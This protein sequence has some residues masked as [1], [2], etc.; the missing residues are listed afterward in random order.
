MASKDAEMKELSG[1][2]RFKMTKVLANTLQ[3]RIYLAQDKAEKD[4]W[5]VVKETWKELVKQGKSRDGHK[6]PENFEREKSIQLYLSNLSDQNEGYVRCIES[7][8]DE[9]CYYL[10]MEY[11]GAGELFDF[12]RD[13]HT[14]GE[15]SKIV[16]NAAKQEQKCETTPNEWSLCVQSMFRQMVDTVSWMHLHGVSHLDL[17]LENTMLASV[18]DKH[19]ANIKI[20]DFGVAKFFKADQKFNEKVG[21]VGYM[22]PEVY[23]KKEY[24]PEK[25]DIWC[26]GVMLFMML[27]GAPPYEFASPTNPAFRFIIAGRLR[28]VLTHWRR[29]PLVSADALNVME[30]IF[31]PENERITMEELRQHKYVNLPSLVDD[32]ELQTPAISLDTK[33]EEMRSHTTRS[34]NTDRATI[35][36]AKTLTID[37]GLIPVVK[38]QKAKEMSQLVQSTVGAENMRTLVKTIEQSIEETT[39]HFQQ[40]AATS[41]ENPKAEGV[42]DEESKHDNQC[43]DE[44]KKLLRVVT[45]ALESIT[46]T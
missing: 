29:L 19:Q 7:W 23:A 26:L 36:N 35:G 42:T 15:Q 37:S 16:K 5:T 4:R 43:L 34:K 8:E 31:K 3:G 24:L 17:S 10:A 12:I 25:A 30:K 46:S 28:D 2:N 1:R 44:L 9:N 22:A 11:C 14:K 39:K 40:I 33:D 41:N 21:K 18:I 32:A 27:V 13:N 38:T 45:E 20:I 6:V